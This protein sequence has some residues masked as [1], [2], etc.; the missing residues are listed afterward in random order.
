MMIRR[1]IVLFAITGSGHLFSILA[2]K[3]MAQRGQTSQVADIGEVESLIQLMIGLIGFGM[4]S[5][6]IRN[7]TIS[8][9]HWKDKFREAQTAR[10]TLSLLLIALISLSFVNPVYLCFIMAPF[11]AASGDYALY[12]KGFPITGTF[13]A[14]SR[15]IFPLLMSVVSINIW[16]NHVFEVYVGATLICYAATNAFIS[17]F[18]KTNYFYSPSITS[19]RLYLK[20]LPLGII[21]LCF[22]FF[23]LGI[24]LLAQFFFAGEELV[25]S[26]L[27]LKFYVIF[28]GAIRVIHQAFLNKMTHLKVCLSIDQIS[29][30]LS[31][32]FLGSTLIYPD[33]FISTFFGAQFLPDHL[34]FACIALSA[35]VFSIMGSASTRTILEGMDLKYMKTAVAS[36]VISISFF[37]VIYQISDNVLSIAVSLLAGELA[38]TILSGIY[39]F[40]PK[41]VWLRISFVVL[42]SLVLVLPLLVKVLFGETLLTY[43]I[44]FGLM[45]LLMLLV[46]YRRINLSMSN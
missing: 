9:E 42:C 11:F 30:M 38:F 46:T 20:T 35:L 17:F 16:P 34:F 45:G 39:F 5:D 13:V 31:L 18:L 28:K 6:A 24:L 8:Q 37:G 21:T 4:Q 26:F 27:A 25:I 43:I 1:I 40:R 41:D 12:A 14:F 15:A 36:V 23:G 7:I 19:L 44:G 29:I 10:I 2:L 32:I 22:Y 3:F 33:I